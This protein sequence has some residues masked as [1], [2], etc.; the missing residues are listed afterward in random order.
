MLQLQ[1]SLREIIVGVIPDLLPK[2]R[3][4]IN[5]IFMEMQLRVSFPEE[6]REPGEYLVFHLL[7]FWFTIDSRHLKAA[8]VIKFK[9]KSV[10]S[11]N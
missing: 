10:T 6:V 1:D 7:S 9:I 4:T 8:Y 11:Q 2:G 3:V 5:L